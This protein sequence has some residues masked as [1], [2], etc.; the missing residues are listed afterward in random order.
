MKKSEISKLLHFSG[1]FL[2]L[3]GLWSTSVITFASNALTIFMIVLYSPIEVYAAYTIGLAV[4]ALSAAWSDGGLSRTMQVMSAQ[5]GNQR[6]TLEL[7]RNAGIRFAWRIVPASY[8][9]IL[10]VVAV[11]LQFSEPA[12]GVG[13]YLL[14]AF[15]AIGVLRSRA[16]FSTAL[17]YAVG[18]F[19]N[20]N[21]ARSVAAPARPLLIGLAILASK[22]LRLNLLVGAE[23]LASLFGWVVAYYS[24]KITVKHMP[25]SPNADRIESQN[26]VNVEVGRFLKPSFFAAAFSSL[27]HNSNV[28]GASLFA[29]SL[30]IAAFGS[31]QRLNQIFSMFIGQ[32]IPYGSRRLRL[33]L[34]PADKRRKEILAICGI[35]LIYLG[36]SSFSFILYR[37]AGGYFQHYCLNYPVEFFIFLVV[38]GLGYLTVALNSILLARGKAHHLVPGTLMQLVSIAVLI[39]LIRPANLFQIVSIYGASLLLTVLYYGHLFVKNVRK[40]NL[41]T[42]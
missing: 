38:C 28:F 2:P 40:R 26:N 16:N 32:L 14:A 35:M 37:I 13:F 7:Y 10:A 21:I 33:V 5:Q 39:S 29:P 3:V 30:S 1:H 8:A 18:H 4:V 42:H 11:L 22:A 31:F 36:Y 6:G 17:I 9:A 19:R 20:Y 41:R 34:Q 12:R 25:Y 27:A 23:M 24:L 15:G